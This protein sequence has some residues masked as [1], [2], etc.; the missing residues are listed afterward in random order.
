MV[1]LLLHSV[2]LHH[3]LLLSSLPSRGPAM[4]ICGGDVERSLTEGMA[5]ESFHHTGAT[6]GYRQREEMLAQL[7]K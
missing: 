3:F 2:D 4:R 6:T 7:D 5:D 1:E